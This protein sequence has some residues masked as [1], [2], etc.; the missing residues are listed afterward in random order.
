MSRLVKIVLGVNLLALLA[1]VFV[2]PQLMVAPGKLIPGHRHLET[3][4]F[5]CH[6]PWSGAAAAR[7]ASCHKPAEI[8]LLTSKGLPIVKPLTAT[9]FHQKLASQDC[10]ACH[11]DH[12]GIKRFRQQGRFNH[13]L[14]QADTRQ[15][16]QGCHKTPADALHQQISGNC[17]QCHSQEK[18]RPASFEHAKYFALDRDHQTQ[19]ATCHTGNDYK[20]YTCYGCHEHTPGNIRGEH[21]EEGIR[22]F[23]NC[24]S[25]HRSANKHDI[26]RAG[27]NGGAGSADG[28]GGEG[29]EGGEGGG[30]HAAG[31]GRKEHDD[32]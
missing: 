31:R 16:C 17:S 22:S 18:W 7:C 19:C 9:P 4:C 2:F 1:L 15:Q 6:T 20:R 26:R 14:L 11:S 8:G 27:S 10:V 25:C 24:V 21:I 32:D 12:A 3:D 13:A 29:G 28:A 30:S 23:E 5:A